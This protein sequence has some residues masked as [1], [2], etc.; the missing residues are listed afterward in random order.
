[1][2]SYYGCD[3]LASLCE[4]AMADQLCRQNHSCLTTSEDS[5]GVCDGVHTSRGGALL[6]PKL[7][8][9]ALECGLGKLERCALDY[10]SLVARRLW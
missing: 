9:L 2:S 1:M 7:L 6:A 3:R 4:K 8:S 10:V 5:D